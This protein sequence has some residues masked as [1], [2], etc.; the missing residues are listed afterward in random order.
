MSKTPAITCDGCGE[1]ARGGGYS[2]LW[3]SLT[4]R[5]WTKGPTPNTHYCFTCRPVCRRLHDERN[6]KGR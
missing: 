2:R 4:L 1:T 3:H 6:N 5:G